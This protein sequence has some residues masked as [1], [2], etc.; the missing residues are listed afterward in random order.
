MYIYA[1]TIFILYIYYT[2]NITYRGSLRRWW[3]V[4]R[5]ECTPDVCTCRYYCTLVHISFWILVFFSIWMDGNSFEYHWTFQLFQTESPAMSNIRFESYTNFTEIALYKFYMFAW[6]NGSWN[7]LAVLSPV[8]RGSKKI[9]RLWQ[10]CP[11]T[12]NPQR[13][14]PNHASLVL[15]QGEGPDHHHRFYM[16]L[17][18][19]GGAMGPSPFSLNTLLST[20]CSSTQHMPVRSR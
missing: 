15:R 17:W 9:W 2:Y 10:C 1:I 11:L 19:C 8:S 18:F 16:V 14:L 13:K 12:W 5:M 20:S 4:F 6:A 7:L 3:F